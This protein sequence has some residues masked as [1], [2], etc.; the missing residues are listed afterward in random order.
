MHLVKRKIKS[1]EKNEEKKDESLL[2]IPKQKEDKNDVAELPLKLE[3][4]ETAVK[5]KE[6]N[7][8]VSSKAIIIPSFPSINIVSFR[9]ESDRTPFKSLIEKSFIMDYNPDVYMQMRGMDEEGSDLYDNDD[10][11][12]SINGEIEKERK[13]S[14]NRMSGI[15]ILD[16]CNFMNDL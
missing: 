9:F 16:T 4:Q 7:C 5:P 6:N 14:K 3:E 11:L 12:L 10:D 2:R 8:P 13:L 15:T 1:E